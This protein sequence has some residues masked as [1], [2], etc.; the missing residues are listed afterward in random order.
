MR[1]GFACRFAA[2]FATAATL[3]AAGAAHAT[4]MVPLD[5]GTLT[6]RAD[7]VVLGVV[8]SQASH[9]TAD[10]DAIYT[11]VAVR[12]TRVYKGALRTGDVVTVRREGG[13]V[14]GVGMRVF[15]AAEF[16]VGE[17][18]L[19]FV[20]TRAGASWVSGMSQ[21]KLRV[22]TAAD[23]RKLVA[24]RLAGVQL[25]GPSGSAQP[26]GPRPL[27]DVEREIRAYVAAQRGAK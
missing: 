17:E 18:A 8:E 3:A 7:R 24:P 5:L 26:R 27:D 2:V 15:G 23:G 6:A 21:G 22:S 14:D 25:L 11:D 4:T 16:T 10:H 12:V 19:V 9:W 13:S 1:L 20:E